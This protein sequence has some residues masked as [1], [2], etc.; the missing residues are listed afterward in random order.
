MFSSSNGVLFAADVDTFSRQPAEI[1]H[2]VH[3]E[4]RDFRAEHVFQ[5][6]D[7]LILVHVVG[8]WFV[9]VGVCNREVPLLAFAITDAQRDT[10][11][12]ARF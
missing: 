3:A 4:L 2:D 6:P 8:V 7:H 1:V 12:L 11:E 9:D 5:E 10:D